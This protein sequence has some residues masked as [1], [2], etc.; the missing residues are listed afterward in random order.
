VCRDQLRVDHNGPP[1]PE[2]GAVSADESGLSFA[3]QHTVVYVVDEVLRAAVETGAPKS[4][5]DGGNPN[6]KRGWQW[7]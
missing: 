6:G 3:R 7:V 5:W 4:K 2:R 1:G